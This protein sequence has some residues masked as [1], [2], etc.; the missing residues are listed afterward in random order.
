MPSE[1]TPLQS[2]ARVFPA[3]RGEYGCWISVPQWDEGWD[4][5]YADDICVFGQSKEEIN[6]VLEKNIFFHAVG[7]THLQPSKMWLP[8]CH[9][10]WSQKV[11]PKFSTQE[12]II[13]G[14]DVTLSCGEVPAPST[15]RKAVRKI[16]TDTKFTNRINKLLAATDQ[17]RS[18]HLTSQHSSSS[19]WIYICT[20]VHI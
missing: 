5:A 2:R 11:C 19:H 1:S 17:G 18:F 13:N 20:T 10:S 6:D 14:T 4:L 16:L 7:R 15:N 9:Q 12:V 8:I 3:T